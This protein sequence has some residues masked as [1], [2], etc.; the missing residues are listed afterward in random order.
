MKEKIEV[1]IQTVGSVIRAKRVRNIEEKTF[2][3][4]RE[5][6]LSILEEVSEEFRLQDKVIESISFKFL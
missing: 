6:G 4:L 5:G 3:A 2:Q 1:R